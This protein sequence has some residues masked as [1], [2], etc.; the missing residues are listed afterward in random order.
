M[1]NR[2]LLRNT[3][4]TQSL[5]P[6]ARTNGTATGAAVDLRGF[7]G[8]MITVS[9]GTWTDGTHTPS[10]NHSVDGVSYAA[11]AASDLDNAFTAVSSGAGSNTIQQVGYIG[12]RRFVQVV[13]VTS[14][15]TTGA[16]SQASVIAGY[17]GNAPTQ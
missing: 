15:A 5:S 17:P 12:S 6:A 11:C 9:F 4:V 3:L 13:M 16:V 14:G 8:A 1:A 7:D 2:D 10:L